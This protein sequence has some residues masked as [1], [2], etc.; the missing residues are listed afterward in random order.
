MISDVFKIQSEKK[1]EGVDVYKS[2][3][4]T[5]ELYFTAEVTLINPKMGL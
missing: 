2:Y 3:L 5:R 1:G 4:W